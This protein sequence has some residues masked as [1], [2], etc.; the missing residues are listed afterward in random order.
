MRGS[1][2]HARCHTPLSLVEPVRM[3]N[4]GAR[5]RGMLTGGRAAGGHGHTSKDDRTSSRVIPSRVQ[6]DAGLIRTAPDYAARNFFISKTCSR[7]RR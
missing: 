1:T 2:R 5:A 6:L 3:S 4:Q 7:V